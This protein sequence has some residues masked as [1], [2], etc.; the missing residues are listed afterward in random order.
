MRPIQSSRAQRVTSPAVSRTG[1]PA[2][3]ADA[4]ARR[5]GVRPG[6]HA[7]P[8][9]TRVELEVEPVDPVR[10]H[11]DGDQLAEGGTGAP[12]GTAA[13]RQHP[14]LQ[15]GGAGAEEAAGI[16]VARVRE[17]VGVEVVAR[18]DDE[19]LVTGADRVAGEF[20]VAFGEPQDGRPRR[21]E[22]HR[23]EERGAQVLLRGRVHRTVGVH[24]QRVVLL[25]DAGQGL[26]MGQ[27][28]VQQ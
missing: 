7:D 17:E 19:D 16:E 5:L 6:G 1:S 8:A 12:V 24:R 18:D 15:L 13:E 22:P 25:A 14:S 23:L 21:I 28:A 27:E 2:D 11:L 3:D 20:D 10:H 9:S 26:G 4:E